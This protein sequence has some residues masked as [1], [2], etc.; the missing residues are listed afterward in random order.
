LK[1]G[2]IMPQ[3]HRGMSKKGDKSRAK[4]ARRKGKRAKK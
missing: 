2:E 3:K 1:E 4:K